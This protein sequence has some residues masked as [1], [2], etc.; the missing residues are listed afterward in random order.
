MVRVRVKGRKKNNQP[1]KKTAQQNGIIRTKAVLDRPAREYLAALM[2]P[3]QGPLVHGLYANGGS[4]IIFR[5]ESSVNVNWG[6]TAT[7]GYLHYTPGCWGT[8]SNSPV[9]WAEAAS[10][11]VNV[12]PT[13]LTN[14]APGYTFIVNSFS[15]IRPIAACM[16]VM[17]MGSES[18]RAGAIYMGHT[19]GSYVSATGSHSSDTV[20]LGLGHFERTPVSAVEQVWRPGDMDGVFEDVNLGAAEVEGKNSLTLA[21]TG[22]SAATPLRVRLITIWECRP[23]SGKGIVADMDTMNPS[24]NTL[25]D[26]LNYVRDSGMAWV[27]HVGPVVGSHLAAAGADYVRSVYYAG[28][29]D[30]TRFRN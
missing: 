25:A 21:W 23:Q 13:A 11:G 22:L 7:S 26:V 5:T 2:D 30:P 15:A 20:A 1:K 9:I 8:G 14:Y 17:Y 16:Q 24:S 18:S 10:G 28:S 19:N 4:G 29:R 12:T 27:R 3:C 6:A